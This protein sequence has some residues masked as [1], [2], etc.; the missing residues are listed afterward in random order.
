MADRIAESIDAVLAS[1]GP[2]DGPNYDNFAPH[3]NASAQLQK[4]VFAHVSRFFASELPIPDRIQ[5][6]VLHS[7]WLG[8]ES[9]KAVEQG[10]RM[11]EIF[12]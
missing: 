11:E 10:E 9:G 1:V 8:F 12:G 5:L 4:L 2:D 7:F 3:V 6:A